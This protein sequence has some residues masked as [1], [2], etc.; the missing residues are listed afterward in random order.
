LAETALPMLKR[1]GGK[2]VDGYE[3]LLSQEGLSEPS[4]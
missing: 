1:L 3:T 2:G 4:D